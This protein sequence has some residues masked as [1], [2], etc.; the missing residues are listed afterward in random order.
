MIPAYCRVAMLLELSVRGTMLSA[1][2]PPPLSGGSSPAEGLA[3]PWHAL[4]FSHK[5]LAA[6]YLFTFLEQMTKRDELGCTRTG[7]K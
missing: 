4:Y 5:G 7:Q 6:V 3:V 1:K 2:L